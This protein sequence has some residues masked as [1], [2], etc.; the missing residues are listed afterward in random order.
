MKKRLALLLSV[1]MAFSM[2]ANV[3]FGADAAKTTQEKFD[4]LKTQGVFNGYPDGSAGLEKEMTRGEFAKVLVKLFGLK[5]IHGTYSYKD[6]NYGAKN[7]AAPF[8]E[9]VTAEGLMQGKDLTKKI[10]DFN[11]KITIE[12]ASKTL[13]S[14]LKLEP[15]KDAQNNASA[16]AKGYFQAAVDAGL[17]SKDTNPKANATRSQL[18]EAA[19]AADELVK[20]PKVASYKVIDSK[21]VEFTMTDKEVVKVTLEKAL[22]ANKETEVKFQYK[23]KDVTAKVT[24][25]VTSA[26]KIETVTADN[27]KELKIKFNGDVD[28]RTAENVDNYKISNVSFESAT[29]SAD[30]SEVTLLAK[31]GNNTNLLPQQK[32]AKLEIKNVKN[33][34]GSKTF[35]ETIKFTAVD[36]QIPTVKEAKALGTKAFKV[37]FSEPVKSSTASNISNYK[38]DGKSISGYVKFTYPNVAF[39]TTDISVGEHKLAVQGVE[40]FAGFKMIPA[41]STITVVEDTVAPE[42]VSAKAKDLTKV[43]IEF[44]ESVKAVSKAYHTST[45]RSAEKIE[46]KDNKVILTFE[47]KDK[48]GMGESTIYLEGVKDYSDNSANRNVKV[49]PELDTTRPTVFGVKSEVNGNNTELTVEFSKDVNKSDLENRDNYVLKNDKGEVY[50]GKGFDPKGHPINVPTYAKNDSNKELKNKVLI[51]SIGKLPAGKYTLEVAGIRDT[52]AIG[53]TMLPESIKVDVTETDTVKV[54]S[55]WYEIDGNDTVVTVQFNKEM[56]RSGNGNARDINK[57]SYVVGSTYYPFPSKNAEINLIDAKTVRITVPTKDLVGLPATG[58]KGLDLRVANVADINDNYMT[59]ST[60]TIKAKGENTIEITSVKAIARDK[61]EIEFDGNIVYVD[62]TDFLFDGKTGVSSEPKFDDGKTKVEIKF[63]SD[64]FNADATNVKFATV[65]SPKS[66]DSYNNKVEAVTTARAIKDGIKPKLSKET[67]TVA[68]ATYVTVNFDENVDVYFTP[69][70]FK[71]YVNGND[72]V[73]AIGAVANGKSITI[74]LD[75]KLTAG[76][77]VSVHMTNNANNKFVTDKS[78]NAAEDFDTQ[79]TAK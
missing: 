70:A 39:I 18:V 25:A 66:E 9:A 22:E 16:W 29:L 13:V 75:K 63:D 21:N 51:K 76:D 77:R 57:Y 31:E 44:N 45:N 47:D 62:Q 36:T 15:V 10:F 19:Y 23:G 12:E 35:N 42:I 74:Q 68:E 24:Y 17:F 60:K 14:A 56:A 3:A 50:V 48:L 32:E 2:F 46:I 27:Y 11:G 53:N 54:S 67:L 78:K 4:A 69:E 61:V 73:K 6:K 41:D 1:A 20:G 8:I 26:Q 38:I 30:K 79:T 64:L 43:E 40:D 71:V 55:A 59:T 7:W 37:V 28:A 58:L 65:A 34:D 49:T 5:E 52:A 33:S 72:D